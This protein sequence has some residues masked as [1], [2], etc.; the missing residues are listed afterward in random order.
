M[1]NSWFTAILCML[2]LSMSAAF[3]SAHNHLDD[4]LQ[5]HV[6]CV[7]CSGHTDSVADLTPPANAPCRVSFVCGDVRSS[8]VDICNVVLSILC[9]RGPPLFL[10]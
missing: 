1:R 5:G 4:P 9:N 8:S 7:A 2:Y 6:Q 3:A 10:V